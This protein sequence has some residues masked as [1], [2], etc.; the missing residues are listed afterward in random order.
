MTS[1]TK[2]EISKEIYNR[3]VE[4]RGFVTMV[5]IMFHSVW[6]I[7]AINNNKQYHRIESCGTVKNIQVVNCIK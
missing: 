7:R 2:Y 1:T 6:E 5:S 3:A 4:N